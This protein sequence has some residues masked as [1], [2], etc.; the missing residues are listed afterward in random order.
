MAFCSAA[1]S[2][3]VPLPVAPKAVTS[4]DDAGSA[5][6]SAPLNRRKKMIILML[7]LLRF[8]SIVEGAHVEI[9]VVCDEMTVALHDDP[10]DALDKRA[11]FRGER[12]DALAATADEFLDSFAVIA[13]GRRLEIDVLVDL[14]E[15]AAGFFREVHRLHRR[16]VR[17]A[18][19]AGIPERGFD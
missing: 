8:G 2:R 4:N 12:I 11:V 16:V 5:A 6:A 13:A 18:D 19:A 15:L 7:F 14:R 10:D 17:H 3:V 1:V 9:V